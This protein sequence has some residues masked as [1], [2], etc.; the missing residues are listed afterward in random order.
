MIDICFRK[1]DNMA[2]KVDH[3]FGLVRNPLAK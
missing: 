2:F 3:I 1:L